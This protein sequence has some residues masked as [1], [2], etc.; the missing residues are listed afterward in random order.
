MTPYKK[1]INFSKK[2]YC[3]NYFEPHKSNSSE[4][5]QGIKSIASSKIK[6]SFIPASLKNMKETTVDPKKISESFI[7]CFTNIKPKIAKKY[8]IP[9][10]GL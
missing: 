7:K 9:P 2:E 3:S 4:I 10:N 5:W 8:L 6:N 1:E